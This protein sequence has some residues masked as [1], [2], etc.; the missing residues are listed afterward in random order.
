MT[1]DPSELEP[2]TICIS[3]YCGEAAGLM[4]RVDTADDI[5]SDYQLLVI[6]E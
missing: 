4:I 5:K 6:T 3:T 1:T 2:A